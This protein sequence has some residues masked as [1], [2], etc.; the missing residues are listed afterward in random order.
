MTT[1]SVTSSDSNYNF[2]AL[3]QELQRNSLFE[4]PSVSHSAGLGRTSRLSSLRRHSPCISDDPLS[5]PDDPQTILRSLLRQAITRPSEQGQMTNT[6]S[7]NK[8]LGLGQKSNSDLSLEKA[9][10]FLLEGKA[11]PSSG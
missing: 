11:R 9:F 8:Q 10:Q 3:L 6:R 7:H 5:D 2:T 1:D 4:T